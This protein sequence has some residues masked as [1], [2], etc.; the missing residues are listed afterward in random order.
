MTSGD[1]DGATKVFASISGYNDAAIW[2]QESQYQKGSLLLEDGNYDDA[3]Q[4]FDLISGYNN[5]STLANECIYRKGQKLLTEGKFDEAISSFSLVVDYSDAETQIKEC[6]Y[7]K[8]NTLSTAGD[9]DTA[10]K[11]Y[12]LL[13][14]YK[15]VDNIIQT[16][17]NIV[18]AA[19]RT[20]FTLGNIV[21][22]GS[23]EQDNDI[24]NG[25]EAIEWIVLKNDGKSCILISKY[26]LE[27][28]SFNESRTSVSW[29][30][31]TLHMWLNK[32]FVNAAFSA[33]EKNK[34]NKE[35][36]LLSIS[37]A[38]ALF[39]GDKARQCQATDYAKAHGA[40]VANNGSSM[41]WLRSPGLSADRATVVYCDGST[42]NHRGYYVSSEI[43]VVRPVISLRIA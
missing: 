25:A 19:W 34:L 40:Y 37:E 17:E 9:Y 29:E 30:D 4:I 14:G 42:N 33:E 28:R 27:C 6:Q 1:Y 39:D 31:C 23:F 43:E 41:W 18:A 11:I 2:A 12:T 10:Y 26:A 5:A 13:A 32:D 15:D 20:Q 36:Y 8:A 22:Y 35:V 7:Q 21:T 16:N 24:S 38:D 3:K